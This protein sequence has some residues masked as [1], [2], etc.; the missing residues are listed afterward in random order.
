M[1]LAAGGALLLLAA[2]PAAAFLARGPALLQQ[3]PLLITASQSNKKPFPA[4]LGTLAAKVGRCL[5]GWGR[6]ESGG[7]PGWT[8]RMG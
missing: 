1:L 6:S 7:G 8:G 4:R 5:C 3:R 2:Q